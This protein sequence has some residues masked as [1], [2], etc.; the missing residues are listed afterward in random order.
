M[1]NACIVGI[2]L[3]PET[4]KTWALSHHICSQFMEDIAGLR[5]DMMDKAQMTHK[6]EGK[7]HIEPDHRDREGLQSSRRHVFIL[8]RSNSFCIYGLFGKRFLPGNI[9]WD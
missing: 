5:E 9:F 6:E 7:A 2:M 8:S 1:E 3:K 4:L